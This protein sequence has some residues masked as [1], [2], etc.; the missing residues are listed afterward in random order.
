MFGESVCCRGVGLRLR[1]SDGCGRGASCVLV[2]EGWALRLGDW[3]IGSRGS[4][5]ACCRSWK[6][7]RIVGSSR[8]L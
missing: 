6:K 2:S 3:E 4:P 7:G 5:V 1:D 8:M